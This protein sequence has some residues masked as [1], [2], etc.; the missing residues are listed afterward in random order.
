MV[1]PLKKKILCVSSLTPLNI[2]GYAKAS[3]RSDPGRHAPVLRQEAGETQEGTNNTN[4]IHWT[5]KNQA[6]G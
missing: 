3:A 6:R 2:L 4:K 1:R 5:I